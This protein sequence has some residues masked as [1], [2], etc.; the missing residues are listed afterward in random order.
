[1]GADQTQLGTLTKPCSTHKEVTDDDPAKEGLS[2]PRVHVRPVPS[3]D[4]RDPLNWPLKLKVTFLHRS[5]SCPRKRRS[6]C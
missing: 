2:N 5:L 3:E 4:P 1:M 6:D